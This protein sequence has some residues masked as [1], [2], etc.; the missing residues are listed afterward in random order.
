MSK[1]V[2]VLALGL[3]EQ[4]RAPVGG[5]GARAPGRPRSRPPRRRS[6]S[7]S[8]TRSSR[9][10][11]N[12][13]TSM[14]G[15][16]A[17]PSV[18]GTLPGLTVRTPQRPSSSVPSGRSRGTRRR[19]RAGRRVVEAPGRIGLPGLDQRVGHRLARAVVDAC[20][21]SGWRP[22]CRSARRRGPSGQGSPIAKNGPTVCDGGLD[23]LH[24]CA[25][26]AASR[27][28]RAARCPSGRRAP[29]S[30]SVVSRS[31]LGDHPLARPSGRGTELKIGSNG[32]SG[33]PGKY[34]CVTSRWAKARPNSE[35]WMCA[36]RQALW[37]LPHG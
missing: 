9:P 20:R 5:H 26:S 31:K 24:Q 33:S 27:R 4:R 3:G 32:N 11:A 37:W 21:G 10:R 12:T 7:A 34:I 22:A 15:A 14:C 18:S 2:A 16:C 29:T 8:T 25:S 30:G 35:K 19:G 13:D 1:S 28:G 6:R 36:G 17:R 23:E